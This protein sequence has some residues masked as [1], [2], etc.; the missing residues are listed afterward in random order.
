M[1]LDSSLNNQTN[2]KTLIDINERLTKQI[3]DNLSL[4]DNLNKELIEKDAA[5]LNGERILK[6]KDRE[7]K[8]LK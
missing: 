7:V 4:F 8:K 6:D 5:L 2:P 1:I 3:E